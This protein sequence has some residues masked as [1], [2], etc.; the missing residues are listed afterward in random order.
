MS[1]LT[2][3]WARLVPGAAAILIALLASPVLSAG[4]DYPSRAITMIVPFPAGGPSDIGGRALADAMG[5]QLGQAIVIENVGGA[6]GNIGATRTAH[7]TADGYTLMYTNFSL[8][9][10]PAL[11]DNLTYDAVKDFASIGVAS[12]SATLLLARS[13]FPAAQFPDLLA[14]MK[15]DREKILMATSGPGGPSDLCALLIMKS[16][17]TRFTIV[18]YKGTGPAMTDVIAGHVDLMCDSIITAAPQVK[19]GTVKT[20]GVTGKTRSA[21]APDIPTLEEQGLTGVDYSVWSALYAPKKTPQAVIER[22]AGALQAALK[23]PDFL[24]VSVTLGQEIAP[25]DLTTPSGADAFLQSEIARWAP[26]LS[27]RTAPN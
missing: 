13:D 11:Y 10:S 7:A 14:T 16:L 5:R 15:T 27:G 8:A 26:L 19:A 21:V 18:P 17:G 20:Y 24:K 2:V 25:G 1:A 6:G 23:D 22:L 4:A 3:T 9:I 12:L